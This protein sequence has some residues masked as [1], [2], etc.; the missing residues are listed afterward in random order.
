VEAPSARLLSGTA[1]AVPFRYGGFLQL[2]NSASTHRKERDEWDTRRKQIL[3]FWLRQND[4]QEQAEKK[5]QV[6][7]ARPGA[8]TR[9][10]PTHDDETVMNG[11][12][13]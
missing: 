1:E 11:A 9:R 4:E 12:P 7:E 3:R 8:P 10:Y 2:M 5:S 6:S 13:R